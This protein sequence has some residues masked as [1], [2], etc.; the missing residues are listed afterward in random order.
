MYCW[1]TIC[2]DAPR[3]TVRYTLYI[4]NVF[5]SWHNGPP[6]G[7]S[8]YKD[9]AKCIFLANK[10]DHT[11]LELKLW[12]STKKVHGISEKIVLCAFI[13]DFD[14][15]PFFFIHSYG[16]VIA[17]TKISLF[18]LLYLIRPS[19]LVLNLKVFICARI[20]RRALC[21]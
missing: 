17:R 19:W 20:S 21:V 15:L 3:V 13:L 6:N 12:I 10:S 1:Y 4:R 16:F 5:L 8:L 7:C 9:N 14:C 18:H 2:I 11:K